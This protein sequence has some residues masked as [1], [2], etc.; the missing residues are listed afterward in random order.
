[1]STA[2]A[3]LLLVRDDLR[4][5]TAGRECFRTLDA[6][7]VRPGLVVRTGRTRLLDPQSVAEG[8]GA[9]LYAVVDRRAGLLQAAER[10]DPPGR[11]GR[12]PLGPGRPAA[13]G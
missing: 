13:A 8:V 9:D 1:M 7:G 10:G 5:V 6:V 4:G 3:W 12:S 11:S 2:G